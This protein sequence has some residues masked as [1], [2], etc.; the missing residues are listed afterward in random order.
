MARVVQ[1]KQ[2]WWKKSRERLKKRKTATTGMAATLIKGETLHEWSSIAFS[3]IKNQGKQRNK[4]DWVNI[5]GKWYLIIDE[6]SMLTREVF[7]VLSEITANRLQD[8]EG[9]NATLPFGGIN[10]ILFGDFHHSHQ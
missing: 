8:I 7:A 3:W 6:S 4:C 1:V 2:H 5:N 10:V 9:F